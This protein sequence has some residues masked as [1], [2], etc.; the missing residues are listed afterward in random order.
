MARLGGPRSG[1]PALR[2]ARR[3]LSPVSSLEGLMLTFSDLRHPGLSLVLALI[4]MWSGAQAQV[5][6]RAGL[7]AESE[8]ATASADVALDSAGGLHMSYVRWEPEVEGA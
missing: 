1:D 4:P 5:A 7:F 3:L 8:R 6:E 2:H